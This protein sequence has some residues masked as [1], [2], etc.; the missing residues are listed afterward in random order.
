MTTVTRVTKY[1]A[2][3]REE[4]LKATLEMIEQSGIDRVRG[5]EVAKR[6]GVSVGLI[7]YHFDNLEK[8]IASA[9]AYAASRDIANRDA[10]LDTPDVVD[11]LHA[12]VR[13]YGPTGSAFGWRLWVES[14]SAGLRD[15]A[16]RKVVQELDAGWR[17]VIAEIIVD[18]VAQR[19][20]RCPD[21]AG[22]AWRLTA[23]LDGLAVQRVVFEGSVTVEQVDEWTALTMSRELG[24]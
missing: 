17:D 21:P 15:P 18:G 10:V 7:F 20:F 3:R 1:S 2:D 24:I 6:V 9:V 16:L 23:M 19:R 8:L 4:I 22:A 14:W 11:R 13:E 5:A 12:A